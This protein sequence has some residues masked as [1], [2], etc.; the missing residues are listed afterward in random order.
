VLPSQN[1]MLKGILSKW[2][3]QDK[4]IECYRF[5]AVLPSLNKMP[6]GIYL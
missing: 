2:N 4:K 3:P 1:E 6:R 5:Q